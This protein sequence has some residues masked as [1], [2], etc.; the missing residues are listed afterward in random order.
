MC[1]FDW[2]DVNA[3]ELPIKEVTGA[4]IGAFTAFLLENRRRKREENSNLFALTNSL[5]LDIAS[6]I[7]TFKKY[8]NSPLKDKLEE[9]KSLNSSQS[10][11]N[12]KHLFKLNPSLKNIRLLNPANINY[13]FF[14]PELVFDIHNLNECSEEIVVANLTRNEIIQSIE[15]R[16]PLGI[17]KDRV[18]IEK[19]LKQLHSFDEVLARK[20]NFYLQEGPRVMREINKI[21]KAHI[22]IPKG[23]KL[24]GGVTFEKI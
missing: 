23:T 19:T 20:I 21:A 18:E 4:F 11:L 7:N 14:Y 24:A 22:E 6:N 10:T 2:L 12:F 13:L 17:I 9:F 5:I 16:N 1:V 15:S 3:R 8:S